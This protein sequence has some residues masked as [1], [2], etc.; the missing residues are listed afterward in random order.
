MKEP[1]TKEERRE[2]HLDALIRLAFEKE[3]EE[4]VRQLSTE[5]DADMPPEMEQAAMRAFTAAMEQA[6]KDAKENH[7]KEK[8]AKTRRLFFRVVEI[9]A[10]LVLLA[11]IA[12]PVAVATSAEFRSKVMQLLIKID[13]DNGRAFFQFAEDDDASFPVVDGWRGEYYPSYIPDGFEVSL[14][15]ED[16]NYVEYSCNRTQS[17][18]FSENSSDITSMIDYNVLSP[19]IIHINGTD[20]FYVYGQE[21]DGNIFGAVVWQSDTKWFEVVAYNITENELLNVAGSIKKIVK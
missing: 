2:Q 21:S 19:Q 6:E 4:A 20:A 1:L 16:A 8:K 12:L 14:L 7:S 15:Y 10:C 5:P 9:A 13:Q 17:I 11:G 18:V 3:E